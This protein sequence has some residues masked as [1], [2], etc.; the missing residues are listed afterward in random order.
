MKFHIHPDI[1]K[2]ETLPASFYKDPA[3]FEMLKER[4]FLKSWQW[5]G[6]KNLVPFAQ[7]TS[8]CTI[9]WVFNGAFGVDK[10]QK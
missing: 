7:S 5:V 6:D 1:K 9:R 4:V 8:F 3:V 10:K 2:A